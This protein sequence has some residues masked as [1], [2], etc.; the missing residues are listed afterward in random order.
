MKPPALTDSEYRDAAQ[1]LGCDVPSIK[2][3]AQVESAGYGFWQFSDT[4]WRPKILFEAHWFSNL[5]GGMYD[6]SHPGISSPTWD[7]TLY[8][9][10]PK[11]YKRLDEACALNRPAGLQ[12]A[13]WGKFQIMGFNYY[14]AGFNKLQ[15]FI[16]AMYASEAEHLKAFCSFVMADKKLLEAIKQ[17]DFDTMALRY[18]GAKAKAIYSGRL[19]QSY[20]AEVQNET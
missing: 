13:S 2:T 12:S 1:M 3:F 10:G 17:H 4:D 9:Y 8:V 5:T 11:E 6:T 19:R 18:N 14:R 20:Q 16:N 7:K 15:D